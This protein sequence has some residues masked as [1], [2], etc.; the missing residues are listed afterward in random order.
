[1]AL[2]LGS[3]IGKIRDTG[4]FRVSPVGAAAL[5]LA[6]SSFF[7]VVLG[8]F[9]PPFYYDGLVYHLTVPK[10][11]LLRGSVGYIPENVHAQF[12]SV[13][14]MLYLMA[15]QIN[16]DITVKILNLEIGVL[17]AAGIYLF[18]RV[19]CNRATAA[20]AA[21]LFL[22]TEA[23]AMTLTRVMIDSGVVLFT[24]MSFFAI[25]LWDRG[26]GRHGRTAI[27]A[28]LLAGLGLCSKY[29]TFWLWAIFLVMVA[30]LAFRR[31]G[32]ARGAADPALFALPSL[33]LLLP[34]MS[35]TFLFTG[36]PVFPFLYNVFGGN[37]WSAYADGRFR[38]YYT[39]MGGQLSWSS[40]YQLPLWVFFVQGP[41]ENLVL[42][43]LFPLAAPFLFL[44]RRWPRALRLAAGAGLVFLPYWVLSSRVLRYLIPVA[45]FFLLLIAYAYA[46]FPRGSAR[47]ACLAAVILFS[48][49]YNLR[50]LV[51]DELLVFEPAGV[52]LGIEAR[53]D[54][55]ARKHQSYAAKQLINERLPPGARILF[56]GETRGFHLERDYVANSGHDPPL[57][58]DIVRNSAGPGE[59][60]RALRE[61]GFTHLLYHP[62]EMVRLERQYGYFNWEERERQLLN[63]FL[64][65]EMWE[66]FR[67]N[68]VSL[69][70][71]SR[72]P[73]GE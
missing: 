20:W 47:R 39:T 5:A 12:P 16:D 67:A 44:V 15:L 51:V 24:F 8:A 71:F 13:V 70:G 3:I 59:I 9:A 50:Y 25:A 22:T 65:R 38:D 33:L 34:W 23:V 11:H 58:A 31:K 72:D 14:Q 2:L 29:T 60:S 21:V 57:I 73:A 62:G 42:G 45:P 30:Y 68:G 7:I 46:S 6:G 41:L 37:N 10:L 55:L 53:D 4:D 54:Y 52:V 35:K 28:G 36:N 69:Y 66:M 26:E 49:A 63:D 27:L 43:P 32:L 19:F 18:G 61:Q 40:V 17:A 1:M 48:M 56:V 64:A